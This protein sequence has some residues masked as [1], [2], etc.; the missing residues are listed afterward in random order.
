ML[1]SPTA[2]SST[3]RP[4]T[5]STNP[6]FIRSFA[7]VL[8]TSVA[9]PFPSCREGK[10]DLKLCCGAALTI[11][12]ALLHNRPVQTCSVPSKLDYQKGQRQHKHAAA[13]L[14]P[15]ASREHHMKSSPTKQER[16]NR[17]TIVI[18][19]SCESFV[20]IVQKI[21]TSSFVY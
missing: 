11:H 10:A 15:V 14:D 9:P 5:T 16:H 19:L 3:W 2:T 17:C 8:P 20:G 13:C 12:R 18:F 7:D 6:L 21:Q 1:S 4:A